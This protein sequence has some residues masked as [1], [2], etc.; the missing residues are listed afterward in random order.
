M[1]NTTST[2]SE[3]MPA[4][5][6]ASAA[7]TTPGRKRIFQGKVSSNKADK[8][9][10]VVIERHVAHPIFKK[11]FKRTKKLMAHDANNECKI[12]DIVKIKEHRPLS[13][14]KKWVLVEIVE[15]AK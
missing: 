5:T 7:A 6:N 9:I 2:Q 3:K 13:K 14:N 12:G 10:T 15:R 4:N 1:E 11:Y 8:T